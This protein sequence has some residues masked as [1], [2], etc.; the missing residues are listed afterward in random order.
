[1]NMTHSTLSLQQPVDALWRQTIETIRER[2]IEPEPSRPHVVPAAEVDALAKATLDAMLTR[3]FRISKLPA[4]EEY[5]QLLAKV[6]YFVAKGK[7][8]Q[9]TLGYAPMKNLNT[10]RISRADWSEYFALTH[11]CTWH[12]KVC[13]VY[14]PGLR[15]KIIFDDST[16]SMA[17]RPDRRHMDG[18]INSI[19]RLIKALRYQSFIV[20]TMR[21]SSFAWLF[22]FGLYQWAEWRVRK[23]E[24]D[25]AN[26]DA[27][28]Q[29]TTFA[30]RNLY[31]PAELDEEAREKAFR[32]A[33]H[34]YRVY[35][36][37]LQLSGFSKLG[38]SIIGMYLDGNQHHIRQEAALHLATLGREQV[39]QPWQGEGA[40]QDNGKGKLVPFVL[41]A[42][43][44]ARMTCQQV[45]DLDILPLEGFESIQVCRE[46]ATTGS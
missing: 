26:G 3:Q 24:R 1:M 32:E 41:T 8:V 35:W 27:V 12:N 42:G 7:P 15:I 46:V 16:V 45:N 30:R 22:N 20:G 29:M 4:E 10:V 28:E 34:R 17:N 44:R 18:Y 2:W 25:P 5:N 37:A 33:S 23:F 31:L 38:N 40:L 9:I 11:L 13:S 36:E 43:R 19:G 6:R 21:Q 39:T 14:P